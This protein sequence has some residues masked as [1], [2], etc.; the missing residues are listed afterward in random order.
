MAGFSGITSI[1]YNLLPL[2]LSS[3]TLL[4]LL[5]IIAS[6]KYN[7]L[8]RLFKLSMIFIG[9]V[10]LVSSGFVILV[11]S[12]FV[13]LV[14]SCFDSVSFFSFFLFDLSV[15]IKLSEFL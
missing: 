9:F 4:G 15:S 11:S 8:L 10:F 3:I 1:V 14:S 13:I 6:V 12:G 5:G 2:V 7:L